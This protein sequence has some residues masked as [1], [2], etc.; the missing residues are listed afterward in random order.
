MLASNF[1]ERQPLFSYGSAAFKRKMSDVLT[2][3]VYDIQ[4]FSV[5]DGPGIRTTV[6]LK[7]CPLSCPWCHSPESQSF[8]PQLSW[9]S[10][11][12][13]GT[14]ACD[15]RCIKAC[16]KGAIELGGTRPDA[17]SRKDLQLV[18]VKRD[19]CDNCG[20][21][22]SACHPHALYICGEDYT[23]DQIAERVLQDRSFFEH[24]GGGVTVSGGEALSQPEFTLALLKRF[25][26]EGLH[27]ALDTTGFAQWKHIEAVLPYTD[28]FL[29]D[30]KHMDNAKHEATVGV[31]NGPILENALKIAA[32]G[33]KFQ[34]RIPV[35]PRF[36][37]DEENIRATAEF[38]VKLGDAVEVIQ[39]L[40]YHNLGVSKYQRISDGPV[41]EAVPPSD[42]KMLHL[43]SIMDSYGLNVMIH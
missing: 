23:V 40:P 39:L 30:L 3:K 27:T 7:G 21:C 19:L 11:R 35:I 28:L 10:M 31:P 32:A 12:C 1:S 34:I 41:L 17:V 38:C 37:D 6:F 16:T 14:D 24:S 33:G 13:S 26:A 5:Q 9:I 2:G 29:Y 42:E 4:G 20:D 8:K 15:S 22:A 36:N 25:K 18:H 43:K